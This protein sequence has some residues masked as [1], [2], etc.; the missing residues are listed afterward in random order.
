M[1]LGRVNPHDHDEQ[2][3]MTVL[4]LKAC[5]ARQRRV[6]A[7]RPRLARDVDAAATRAC[8]RTRCRSATSPTACTSAP[9]WRR[10]C[11]SSTT[12]TSAP[13]GRRAAR[14]PDLW[15]GDR[16]RRRRRAVGDASDAQG[17]ADRL[18]A[19]ARRAAGGAARRAGRRRRAAS[20]RAQPRRA[21]DRLRPPV[22]H[23]QAG[24]PDAAGP[25]GARQAGEPSADAGAVHLR[26][27]GPPARRARA[28]PCCS[29]SPSSRATRRSS[30][31]SS[32]SRTTTSTSAATWCRAW[33]CG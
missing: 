17:A 23:L 30:A 18:H 32:S 20:P 8:A 4:A 24:Q 31:S 1:A 5:A 33:T 12:G 29:R 6:V 26:R 9:G 2:F 22:R 3:C 28:R 21:D 27:Q 14:E 19:A 10:R 16:E 25:R 15:R 13:T 7:A 11:A